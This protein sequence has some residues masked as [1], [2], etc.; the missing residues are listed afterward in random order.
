MPKSQSSQTYQQ[1]SQELDDLMLS[2]ESGELDIDEAVKRY[3]RGLT[4]VKQ[5]EEHL[6]TAENTV[7]RL[8]SQF[9]EDTEE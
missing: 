5:L 1:L 7:K 2:L 3:E 8:R 9:S 4:I 6:N